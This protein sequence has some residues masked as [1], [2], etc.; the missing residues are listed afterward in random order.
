L[1]E[2]LRALFRRKPRSDKYHVMDE[3]NPQ[4]DVDKERIQDII[5]RLPHYSYN[6]TRPQPD[7]LLEATLHYVEQTGGGDIKTIECLCVP[8][9]YDK[10]HNEMIVSI[11]DRFGNNGYEIVFTPSFGDD[12]SLILTPIQQNPGF[13]DT[14]LPFWTDTD[15]QSHIYMKYIII[16]SNTLD[17]AIQ[18]KLLSDQ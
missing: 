3:V 4:T 6:S 14:P 1:A 7:K 2:R 16:S 13:V 18:Q 11:K 9:L 15:M 8:I 5:N 12:S 17:K 10:E